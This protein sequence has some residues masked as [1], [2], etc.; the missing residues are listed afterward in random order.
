MLR[1]R[2]NRTDLFALVPQLGL[3]F[4]SQLEQLDRLLDDDEIVEAIRAAMARRSPRSRS[5]GRPATPVE[6]VL[7][8]LVV[9]RLY[10]WSYAQAEY[11]VND[12]LVLRQSCRAYLE[13]VPDD[14][15]L[16][17]WANTIGPEAPR[18][19]NDRVV[20]L[21][22]SL[23][24]TRGRKLR[25]DT[26]AVETDIH[27]PT[28]SG[29]VGDGVRVVSRL[30]RRARA[31]PGGAA[32]RL[33]EA[34]RSRGRGGPPPSQQLHRVARRKT[35]EGRAALK[36]AYGRLVAVG[37]RSAAQGRRVLGALRGRDDDPA[38]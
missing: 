22:R 19:L 36:A 24:V 30:L 5:R 10:G 31:A 18:A 13:K 11:F 33:K 9:M 28:D 2:Y 8:M 17:R 7:R 6:V 12:S 23:K 26:T 1:H 38:A 25:V 16:I 21:A 35:D 37:R 14:T 29:L 4:E 34:V 3:R 20:Q 32:S 15:A 27:F